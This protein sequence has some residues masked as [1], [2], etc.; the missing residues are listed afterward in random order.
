[1][2]LVSSSDILH[3]DDD[4]DAD[5]ADDFGDKHGEDDLYSFG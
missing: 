4:D 2:N 5:D 3:D 1:M